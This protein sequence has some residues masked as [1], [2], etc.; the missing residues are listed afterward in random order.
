MSGDEKAACGQVMVRFLLVL[1]CRHQ[2]EEEW[3]FIL[4]ME[5]LAKSSGHL[6]G[7][8]RIRFYSVSINQP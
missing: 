4:K 6:E 5:A 7:Q 2:E 1:E 8:V 3:E